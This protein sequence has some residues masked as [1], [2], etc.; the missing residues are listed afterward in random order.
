MTNTQISPEA[1]QRFCDA[2]LLWL[3]ALI[4]LGLLPISAEAFQSLGIVLT[5]GGLSAVAIWALRYAGPGDLTPPSLRRTATYTTVAAA[6]TTLLVVGRDAGIGSADM[7]AMWPFASSL[8]AT[9]TVL[10]PVVGLSKV[11][12]PLAALLGGLAALLAGLLIGERDALALVC[13]FAFAGTAVGAVFAS[14]IARARE[15]AAAAASPGAEGSPW[16]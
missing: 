10:T 15:L 1:E 12:V 2:V 8:A 11:P 6:T 4:G 9:A 5:V 13:E 16:Y 14:L 7:A 3:A